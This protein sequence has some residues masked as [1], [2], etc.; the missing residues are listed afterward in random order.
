MNENIPKPIL[1][2]L[3]R[4]ATPADHPSADVLAAF[5]EHALGEAEKQSVTD[6]LARCGECR[7]IVFLASGD[8]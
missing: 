7:E 8:V 4:E 2:A 6:H 1:D 5:V 3:A